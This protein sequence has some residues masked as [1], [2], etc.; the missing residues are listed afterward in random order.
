MYAIMNVEPKPR[1]RKVEHDARGVLLLVTE[2]KAVTPVIIIISH[3]VDALASRFLLASWWYLA[4]YVLASPPCSNRCVVIRG[5]YFSVTQKRCNFSS[6]RCKPLVCYVEF[7]T[8]R[9]TVFGIR[10]FYRALADIFRGKP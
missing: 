5:L 9:V 4:G 3:T 2:K 8:R 10:R 6:V 7:C 1:N